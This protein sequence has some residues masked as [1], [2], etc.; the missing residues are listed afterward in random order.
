MVLWG[1]WGFGVGVWF[2]R[3]GWGWSW[4]YGLGFGLVPPIDLT[5]SSR[6]CS[7]NLHTTPTTALSNHTERCLH[8]FD[9]VVEGIPPMS[10]SAKDLVSEAVDAIMISFTQFNPHPCLTTVPSARFNPHPCLTT[11]SSASHPLRPALWVPP[12][13]S[14]RA[15]PSL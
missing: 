4:G 9:Y 11:P 14:L 8:P 7:V 10:V 3:C 1:G 12:V 6:H 13:V 5:T 15:L 2:G